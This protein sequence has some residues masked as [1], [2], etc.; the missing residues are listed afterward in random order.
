MRELPLSGLR[1][2]PPPQAGQAVASP[3]WAAGYDF[4]IPVGRTNTCSI[5][6]FKNYLIFFQHLI[7]KDVVCHELLPIE[8]CPDEL[9]LNMFGHK[10]LWNNAHL[11]EGSQIS[12]WHW[13][14]SLKVRIS[15]SASGFS[16]L[17][18]PDYVHREESCNY[19]GECLCVLSL[20]SLYILPSI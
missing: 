19:S 8:T 11:L 13:W 5:R 2:I 14:S 7:I 20:H 4:Q 9:E 3:V 6:I 12:I 17:L 15:S 10:A 1:T 18:Q 16:S